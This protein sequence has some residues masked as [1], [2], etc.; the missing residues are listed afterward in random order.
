MLRPPAVLLFSVSKLSVIRK[1]RRYRAS[2]D[3][4]SGSWR[5]ADNSLRQLKLEKSLS[6]RVHE[7]GL[8]VIAEFQRVEELPPLRGSAER[9]V[10]RVHQAVDADDIVRAL[11][12]RQGEIPAGGDVEVPMEVF[13]DG[14]FK[15]PGHGSQQLV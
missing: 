1:S 12:R 5:M 13:G 15:V 4:M 9:I 11:E 14:K 2:P 10:N 8:I 3:A 7:L 6:I